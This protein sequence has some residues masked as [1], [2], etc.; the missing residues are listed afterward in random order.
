[1][2]ESH[3][4]RIAEALEL[5]PGGIRRTAE[6]LEEQATIPF[7]ARYRK[8]ATGGLDEVQ[9]R[10]IAE[11]L[12]RLE[13]LEKRRATVLRTIEEQGALT[14][15]LRRRIEAIFDP[16]E[17]ED[18]Y[19]P[20]KPKR[21]TR[22]EKAREAGLEPLAEVL[23][24][25]GNDDPVK[26]AEGYVGESV[27]DENAALQ[28]AR[29]ILAE[30]FHEDPELR[31]EMRRLF[32]REAEVSAEVVQG[33][34]EEGADYRDYFHWSEPIKRIPAHRFMAL[35]R[36]EREGVLR[37]SLRPE[38][39]RALELLR[40]R[41]V[42]NGGA[43][44]QQVRRAVEEAWSRLIGP[45]LETEFLSDTGKAAEEESIAVFASNVRQLL[46]APPLGS[47]RVIAVD[48][49]YRT[50]CKVVCLDEQ[51]ALLETAT[52]FPHP[53][54]N[55]RADAERILRELAARHRPSAAA[56]GDG[57][58]GRETERLFREIEFDP[59]VAVF[60]VSEDGASVYSA[61]EIGRKEF[62]E[63]DVTVRGAVS[64]GRR[65]IDPLAELVKIEP[66]SIGVGQYQHDV[67][68]KRLRKALEEQVESCVNLVGV[69]VNT[70]GA[71]LL[72]YVAG[73]GPKTAEALVACR[74]ERGPF[75]SRSELLRVPGLG[76]KAYEQCA[77]FLRIP[78]ADNPLDDSAVHPEAYHLVERMAEELGCRVTD[79]I[80]NGELLS[81]M[82]P[83]RYTDEEFGRATVE[84]I[85]SELAKPGRDPRPRRQEFSFA[86]D[87]TSIEDLEE[88]MVLPGLVTNITRFGAFV[89][90]GVK[91]DGLVHI[92][93]MAERY[94]C[95][96]SEVVALR[97]QVRVMVIAVDRE[98]GRI[99]L[100]LKQAGREES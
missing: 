48:P 38:R 90:V 41:Y 71:P 13:E 53:P 20:Y 92:S 95:D 60:P 26:T 64:I 35:R 96:P 29:D 55:R 9:I 10:S 52:V 28:G 54:H 94:V 32:S 8:E 5:P 1:M 40:R 72:R 51:G 99:S 58:A 73:L 47:A 44:A 56:V 45:S 49:G 36:G 16:K 24:A 70:A 97:E 14:E 42:R 11:R 86:E 75:R 59:P 79:L 84:D 89:D 43:S 81:S 63:Q 6:L 66:A 98:R 4:K 87:I 91:Q 7:I 33:M 12:E 21:R 30:R 74:S 93:E 17:L 85:L 27:P 65:L 50:G 69:D 23:F 3:L 88:G 78:G 100:S 62:P 39:E 67:D 15:E 37:L 25:Q 61:S 22:A 76:P 80:E 18:I 57:T 34:E 19:L 68:Q 31:T 2:R 77:G 82:N 46:L 83:E